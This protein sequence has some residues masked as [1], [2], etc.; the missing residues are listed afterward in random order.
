M[1]KLLL[2]LY[3]FFYSTSTAQVVSKYD[4]IKVNNN[5]KEIGV[6]HIATNTYH[7][8]DTSRSVAIVKSDGEEFK[9]TDSVFKVGS[10]HHFKMKFGYNGNF[11]SDSAKTDLDSVFD[12]LIKNPKLKIQIEQYTDSRG[13][14]EFNQKLS[15]RRAE[16][17]VAYLIDKGVQGNR[18]IAKGFGESVL[19]VSEQA[20]T[21]MSTMRE[22]ELAHAK[23]RR[24]LIRIISID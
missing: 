2:V 12:F 24:W 16:Y 19:L 6:E 21:S 17:H 1:K 18:L 13:H 11:R 20:I 9:L 15:Q 14:S 4:T 3:V 22:K 8:E 5:D 10:I 7:K 23:N